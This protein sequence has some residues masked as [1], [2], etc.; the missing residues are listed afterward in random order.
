MITIKV[1]LSQPVS[2]INAAEKARGW[3]IWRK[4]GTGPQHS[5]KELIE[6]LI[7]KSLTMSLIYI[8]RLG[9]NDP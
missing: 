1:N 8:S 2:D 5:A 4:S 7:K 9:D 3:V 6:I